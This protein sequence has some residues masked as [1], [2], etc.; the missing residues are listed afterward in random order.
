VIP[1]IW[2]E[3]TY[4][5]YYQ[6]TPDGAWDISWDFTQSVTPIAAIPDGEVLF[7]IDSYRWRQLVHSTFLQTNVN[8]NDCQ[9]IFLKP[10]LPFLDLSPQRKEDILINRTTSLRSLGSG[11]WF[12]SCSNSWH[13]VGFIDSIFVCSVYIKECHIS[14]RRIGS[15]LYNIMAW[16][17]VRLRNQ[18][19]S[20][21][22]G[23][24]TIHVPSCPTLELVSVYLSLHQ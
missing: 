20:Y 19:Y 17:C 16:N 3:C 6:V 24:T 9:R 1:S 5:K 23:N 15:V 14:E 7:R 8:V 21:F 10:V 22:V 11:E 2:Y 12:M 13:A 4:T 18:A